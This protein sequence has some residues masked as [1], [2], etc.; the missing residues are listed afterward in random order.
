MCLTQKET[1]FEVLALIVMCYHMLESSH[2]LFELAE[3]ILAE[4]TADESIEAADK[5]KSDKTPEDLLSEFEKM[6]G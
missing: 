1:C 2:C 6:L 5:P 3:E 4:T